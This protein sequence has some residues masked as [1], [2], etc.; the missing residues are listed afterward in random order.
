MFEGKNPLK[1]EDFDSL[2][3]ELTC[4]IVPEIKEYSQDLEDLVKLSEP[5]YAKYR[6]LTVG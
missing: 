3:E 6:E 2:K 5:L 1:V 4:K